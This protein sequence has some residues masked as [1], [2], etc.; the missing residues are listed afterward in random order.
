MRLWVLATGRGR[1]SA[2]GGQEST[3]KKRGLGT[4]PSKDLS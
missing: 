4:P 3:L 2:I 1:K